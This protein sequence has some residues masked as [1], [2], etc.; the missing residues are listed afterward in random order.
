MY[1]SY[2]ISLDNPKIL[3]DNIS[4][5]GLNPILI[6]GVNGSKLSSNEINNNTTLL[7][8]MFC[9]KSVIGIAMSHIKS[10]KEFVKSKKDVALFFEDDAIFEDNFREKLDISLENTPKDFDILYLGCFGCDN[11]INFFTLMN[12]GIINLNSSKVNKYVKKPEIAFALHS[13]VLSR[14]G[15]KKLIK[16]FDTNINYYIDYT[17]QYL[18]RNNQINAYSLNTRIVYQTSTDNTSSTNNNNNHPSIIT[19]ILSNYY[20]DEKVKASYMA[21]LT[22]MRIGNINLSIFSLLF[23]IIG[24]ILSGTNV[25]I[26]QILIGYLLLSSPDLYMNPTNVMIRM[27]FIF[28]IFPFLVFKY[29]NIWNMEETLVI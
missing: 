7:C 5:Y 1:D 20:I 13:Y 2:V 24:I 27:H 3:L 9:P 23:I 10:W 8:S 22:I 21:N 4:K 6:N 25:N 18:I 19:N 12:N 17:I 29:Y 26:Y 14:K 16:Y 28:L 11:F 15:A